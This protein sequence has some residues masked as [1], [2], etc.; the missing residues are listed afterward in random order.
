MSPN[1]L[2]SSRNLPIAFTGARGADSQRAA[3]RFFGGVRPG[4]TCSSAS[5]AVRALVGG[6]ASYA[7]VPLE[8][9]ITGP[10]PGVADAFF[11]G[12]VV[13]VGEVE[14]PI[15][16]CL[17]AVP[18]T[19]M[20]DLTVVT[21]HPS[22]LAQCRDLLNGWGVATRPSSDT[23]QAAQELARSG[24]K[25][26]GVLGSRDLAETYGLAILAEGLSDRANNRTR[27]FVLGP[28][29]EGKSTGLRSAL[30]VGPVQAPRALKT[31]R[32]QL[33]SFGASRVRVPFLGSEDGTRFLGEFDHRGR[34]AAR[35]VS[36]TRGSL[37]V[38]FL[39][40]WDPPVSAFLAASGG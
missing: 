32:I 7:V 28:V 9:S 36:D 25:A 33:E 30:L 39:G 12:E 27:F 38:R 37:P 5:E 3:E 22:A 15:R 40:C 19:R 31:L 8:N 26:L 14:M 34:N 16:H 4:L 17:L 20:E 6:R 2:P 29:S 35:I 11:E 24:D 18:G 23:G 10:F 13:V 21:S 1:P